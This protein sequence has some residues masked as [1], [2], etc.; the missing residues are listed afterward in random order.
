MWWYNRTRHAAVD[1]GAFADPWTCEMLEIYAG[2]RR[3]VWVLDVT[4][5][6]GIP[7]MVALSRRVDKPIEDVVFGFGAHFDPR[8]A[9]RRALNEMNQFLP[10]VYGARPDGTGYGTSDPEAMRWWHQATVAEHSYLA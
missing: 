10:S 2:L 3:E 8:V 5:D 9:L 4:A 6:L 1:L 7:T